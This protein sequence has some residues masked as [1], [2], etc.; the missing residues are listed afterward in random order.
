MQQ[1]LIPEEEMTAGKVCRGILDG[2][3]IALLVALTYGLMFLMFFI[4]Y[5]N[6]YSASRSRESRAPLPRVILLEEES[7]LACLLDISSSGG[8]C[9]AGEPG[10][11][12]T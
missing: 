3:F 12:T 7:F 11:E 5:L 10:R 6:F 4:W 8:Y 2:F 9:G 1:S